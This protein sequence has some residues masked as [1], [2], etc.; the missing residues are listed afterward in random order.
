MVFSSFEFLFVFL[1]IAFFGGA[2]FFLKKMEA[3]AIAFV[4][5]CSL[6]FYSYWNALHILVIVSSLSVNH[7]VSGLLTSEKKETQRRNQVG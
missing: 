1:P 5:F 2:F 6:I 7:F 3:G 4:V